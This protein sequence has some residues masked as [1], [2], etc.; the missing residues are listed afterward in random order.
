MDYDTLAKMNEYM[1]REQFPRNYMD[2]IMQ[3]ISLFNYSPESELDILNF[4]NYLK[5]QYRG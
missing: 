1:V 2:A 5:R 3:I 4:V